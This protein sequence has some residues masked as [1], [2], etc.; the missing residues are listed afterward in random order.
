[1][2]ICISKLANR[3]GKGGS[4]DRFSLLGLQNHCM[5]IAAMKLEDGCFLA[6][7]L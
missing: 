1:M 5:V 2:D 3:R 7:K 6:G 4:S